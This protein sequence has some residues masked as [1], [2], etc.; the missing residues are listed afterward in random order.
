MR[1]RQSTAQYGPLLREATYVNGHRHLRAG[2]GTAIRESDA[3]GSEEIGVM[4]GGPSDRTQPRANLAKSVPRSENE[5]LTRDF[6]PD[7]RVA[8]SPYLQERMK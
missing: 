1:A 8:R 4:L 7:D 2:E 5:P 6:Q 3:A